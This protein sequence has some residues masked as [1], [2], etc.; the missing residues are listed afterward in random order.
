MVTEN[1]S[2]AVVVRSGEDRYSAPL[3]FLNGRFDCKISAGDTGGALCAY[4]TFR[5]KPGGP[6]MH[7]HFE[8]D[9][10]FQVQEGRFRFQ[11]GDQTYELGAGDSILGPRGIPHAFRNL[12]ETARMMVTFIPAGTMEAFFA[13][14]MV[15]PTSEAFR[16]LSRKHGMEVVGP[17]LPP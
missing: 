3:K 5:F 16:D 2:A 8:Q 14:Q 10:W 9:E 7:L 15:D 12:T 17:P 13:T 1:K 11:I 4:D 6:P